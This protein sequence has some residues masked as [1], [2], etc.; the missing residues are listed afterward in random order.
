MNKVFP[1]FVMFVI[2]LALGMG[3]LKWFNESPASAKNQ[4]GVMSAHAT[5]SP[6]PTYAPIQQ[7]TTDPAILAAAEANLKAA[8]INNDSAQKQLEAARVNG[9][10]IEAQKTLAVAEAEAQR[11]RNQAA[12]I[13]FT[14]TAYAPTL[15]QDTARSEWN[16]KT[17]G[18]RQV[19]SLFALFG[20][21]LLFSTPFF[22]AVRFGPRKSESAQKSN[23]HS[24]T[25]PTQPQNAPMDMNTFPISEETFLAWFELVDEKSGKVPS[26]SIAKELFNDENGMYGQ[27]NFRKFMGWLE[28]NSY[29]AKAH[30][31]W[32]LTKK[33]RN[34]FVHSPIE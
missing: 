15:A 28:V 3:A 34:E 22:L 5:P 23:G 4:A 9:A 30:D 16:V 7:A 12:A 26:E 29:I 13:S 1:A 25:Q 27:D 10:N 32:Y 6:A 33:F 19:V 20:V 11:Q 21:A 8:Q 14:A 24:P 17:E 18:F 31:K 2:F